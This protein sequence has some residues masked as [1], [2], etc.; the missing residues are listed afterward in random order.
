LV[1]SCSNLNRVPLPVD[2]PRQRRPDISRARDV[3]GWEPSVE[4]RDGL[5]Q[6][7]GYFEELLR[8]AA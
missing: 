8:S 4:L 5:A 2:D 6:T 1:D 3:L 7:I